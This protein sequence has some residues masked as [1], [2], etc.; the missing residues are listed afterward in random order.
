MKY[1]LW[2]FLKRCFWM[3]HSSHWSHPKTDDRYFAEW[4]Q[5]KNTI[6]NYLT[7][8]LIGAKNPEL[9]KI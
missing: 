7:Y 2:K 1:F 3:K 9:Q 6:K 4:E 5:R 8:K